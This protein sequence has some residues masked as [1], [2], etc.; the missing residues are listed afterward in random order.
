MGLN[1]SVFRL[2][3]FGIEI[4]RSVFFSFLFFLLLIVLVLF[5]FIWLYCV[6][7]GDLILRGRFCVVQV[8]S[9][10]GCDKYVL[11]IRQSRV[12]EK[13]SG[14]GN[15]SK[16]RASWILGIPFTFFFFF[17]VGRGVSPPHRTATTY[18]SGSTL[19]G[20]RRRWR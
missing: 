13:V 10:G 20:V 5:Y 11:Y 7:H 17:C 16:G 9:V 1:K 3:G 19:S 18:Y 12:D 14:F 8:G 6:S 2:R 4:D 15:P